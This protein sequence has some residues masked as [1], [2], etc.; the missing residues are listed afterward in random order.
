MGRHSYR[1]IQQPYCP[2][3]LFLDNGK[4]VSWMAKPQKVNRGFSKPS[5]RAYRSTELHCVPP[6]GPSLRLMIPTNPS[7]M[8]NS[9]V[10]IGFPLDGPR[11]MNEPSNAEQPLGLSMV[12]FRA[13]RGSWKELGGFGYQPGFVFQTIL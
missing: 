13:G 7:R 5:K 4:L 1:V 8:K 11:R 6:E 10:T 3:G 2:A 12:S 9:Q